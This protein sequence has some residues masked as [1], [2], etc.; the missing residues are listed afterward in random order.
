MR[1]HDE[2]KSLIKV[3]DE[4]IFTNRDT[5]EKIKADVI[6]IKIYKDFEELYSHYNNKELGYL[7]EENA[8]PNDMLQYYT[9]DKIQKYGVMAIKIRLKK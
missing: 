3:G 5:E 1:C 8:D 4:I 7:E 6:D 2:E 9:K